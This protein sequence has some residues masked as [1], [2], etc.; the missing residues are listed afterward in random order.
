[1]D[2]DGNA[3]LQKNY[4]FIKVLKIISK[5]FEKIFLRDVKM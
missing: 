2:I 5:I 4:Y 1:M 3:F